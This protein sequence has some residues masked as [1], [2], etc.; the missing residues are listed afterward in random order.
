MLGQVKERNNAVLECIHVDLHGKGISNGLCYLDS[1]TVN[2]QVLCLPFIMLIV[3]S[4]VFP[5]LASMIQSIC[6]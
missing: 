6:L 2:L 5:Q 1:T 4:V 3:G